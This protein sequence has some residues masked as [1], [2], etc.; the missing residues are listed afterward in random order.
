MFSL[1]DYYPKL[2]SP[3]LPMTKL[4][5]FVLTAQFANFLPFLIYIVCMFWDLD[6][7]YW[8]LEDLS[9]DPKYRSISTIIIFLLIRTVLL[10][11]GFLETCRTVIYTTLSQIC[12]INYLYIL[13]QTLAY[14]VKAQSQFFKF[15]M[16]LYIICNILGPG[17]E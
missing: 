4:D 7:P 2:L 12:T 17:V 15:Y 16:Q 13:V 10:L 11:P 5:I 8:V 9:S 3:N 1:T 14:K 6:G